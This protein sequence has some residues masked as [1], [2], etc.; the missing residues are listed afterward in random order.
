MA[1]FKHKLGEGL[2]ESSIQADVTN[3]REQHVKC[4]HIEQNAYVVSVDPMIHFHCP[5]KLPELTPK[6][7][8]VM[9]NAGLLV[10]FL[11]GFV[12]LFVGGE[13]FNQIIT[14]GFAG[15]VVGVLTPAICRRIG[16]AGIAFCFTYTEFVAEK[17]FKF[18]ILPRVFG[19]IY[20]LNSGTTVGA[21]IGAFVGLSLIA[22]IS[23]KTIAKA[24]FAIC[25]ALGAL[26]GMASGMDGE[27]ALRD[28]SG[29]IILSGSI[30]IV[31]KVFDITTFN[32]EVVGRA[33][34]VI[35]THLY[36]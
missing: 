36:N 2:R 16:N 6:A 12:T 28:I 1:H 11:A 4:D 31:L 15:A 24:T 14:G 10:G 17:L 5:T 22:R 23:N 25:M 29:A 18:Y 3:I 19:A 34:R 27:T 20:K 8:H 26:V 30:A 9:L 32:T 7:F 33:V 13:L 21:V 35:T